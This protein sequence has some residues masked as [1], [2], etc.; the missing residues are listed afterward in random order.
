MPKHANP[1]LSDL[2]SCLNCTGP[3]V[4]P[5]VFQGCQH[6]ICGRCATDRTSNQCQLCKKEMPKRQMQMLGPL[7][8]TLQA[9]SGYSQQVE[10]LVTAVAGQDWAE[11]QTMRFQRE[12][13]GR[14]VAA[15]ASNF[16][17]SVG[18]LGSGG[19]P[20]TTSAAAASMGG[21]SSSFMQAQQI[22][23]IS[24]MTGLPPQAAVKLL[25]GGTLGARRTFN[26][27]DDPDELYDPS[28]GTRFCCCFCM[29]CCPSPT[30]TLVKRTW[31]MIRPLF[32]Y[33]AI[34][35]VS[36][37]IITLLN[38]LI[39]GNRTL[40]NIINPIRRFAGAEVKEDT[41]NV[42]R[43]LHYDPKNANADHNPLNAMSATTKPPRRKKPKSPLQS[44]TMRTHEDAEGDNLTV[45]APP[46]PASNKE[47]EKPSPA[48]SV[49]PQRK[50]RKDGGGDDDDEPRDL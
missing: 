28:C 33:V 11:Y 5:Y 25:G 29:S 21:E 24:A 8:K 41:T 23:A 27:L 40:D 26:E 4:K 22:Q 10:E 50:E 49:A 12:D 48:A 44:S 35:V 18:G 31:H 45:V 16:L 32:K 20:M 17:P 15:T 37:W 1:T 2:T 9:Y 13:P 14:F 7:G 39:T 30:K 42:D 36:I 6:I 47:N 38:Y 3:M 19:G 46:V 43:P 34:V